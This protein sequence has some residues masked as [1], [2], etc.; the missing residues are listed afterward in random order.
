MKKWKKL[1]ILFMALCL[2]MTTITSCDKQD[3]VSTSEKTTSV[4]QSEDKTKTE[5]A[6]S[7][8]G[9]EIQSSQSSEM[10]ED[11]MLCRYIVPGTGTETSLL[12]DEAITAK[13]KS[14]GINMNF[15]RTYIPW[16]V[17][18]QKTNVMFATGDEFE[19]IHIMEDWIPSSTYVAQQALAPINDALDQYGDKLKEII[20]QDIWDCTKVNDNIYCVPV[21][22]RD[23]SRIIS[24]YYLPQHLFDKYNIAPPK[25]RMDV[26]DAYDTIIKGENDPDLRVWIKINTTTD[27]VYMREYDSYPFVVLENLFF[28]DQNGEVKPWLYTEEFKQNCEYLGE[29]YS[30]GIIHPDI[31]TYPHEKISDLTEQGKNIGMDLYGLESAR[32]NVPEYDISLFMPAPEKK[33]FYGEWVYMNANAASATSPNPEALVIFFNWL[34]SSQ[35]NYDLLNFGLEGEHYTALEDRRFEPITDSTGANLY[36]FGDWMMGNK[37]LARMHINAPEELA[38]V[39]LEMDSEAGISVAAGFRFNSEAV[40]SEYTS[41]MA[42]LQSVIY[43]I[44]YGVV[45]YEDGYDNA[46]QAMKAAGYDKVVEEFKAQFDTWYQNK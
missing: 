8:D 33:A 24:N 42:E 30:R 14:D 7:E 35:E 4:L 12:I 39:S 34:Y 45:S 5:S 20:P 41:C 9:K 1:S 40:A 6:E 16:D 22:F 26:L 15:S 11:E 38:V 23:F 18:Q 46:V 43:P 28:I 19:M 13:L 31:L 27:P 32:N 44:K 10:L 17:W 21:Y 29:M 3:V 36:D 2:M 37:D 25:N